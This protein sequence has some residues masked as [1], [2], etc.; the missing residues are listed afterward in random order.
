MTLLVSYDVVGC[1]VAH[2]LSIGDFSVAQEPSLLSKMSAV[3]LQGGGGGSVEQ[4]TR[5]R[6]FIHVAT[7]STEEEAEA[8]VRDEHKMKQLKDEA[9]HR[10]MHREGVKEQSLASADRIAEKHREKQEKR[11]KGAR[12][13]VMQSKRVDA[14]TRV[15]EV[16][17]GKRPREAD[18]DDDGNAKSGGDDFFCNGQRMKRVDLSV[19]DVFVESDVV[20]AGSGSHGVDD[21]DVM[22]EWENPWDLDL[23]DD[24]VW[25]QEE[26]RGGDRDRFRRGVG[27]DGEYGDADEIEIDYPTTS[28]GDDDDDDDAERDE[29]ARLDDGDEE[30]PYDEDDDEEGGMRHYDRSLYLDEEMDADP[31]APWNYWK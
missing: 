6:V 21:D 15:V 31:S 26:Q 22:V 9:R 4:P 10:R 20:V 18:E 25:D 7:C 5:R 14:N 19:V 13:R 16:V 3:D 17:G 2:V 12:L 27:D 1:N 28:S 11:V 29:W 8:L 30:R 23:V 24:S